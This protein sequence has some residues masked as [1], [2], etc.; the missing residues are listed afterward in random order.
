[1]IRIQA[2]L[3]GTSNAVLSSMEATGCNMDEAIADACA[4]G[5]ADVDPSVD[6]D[7]VDAA[8]K[9]AILCALAFKAR[10]RPS[11]IDARTTARVTAKML[12][13]AHERGG[14]IRQLAYAEYDYERLA[15]IAWVAPAFVSRTTIFAQMTGPKNAAVITGL[16]GGDVIV[17][18][19][20]AGGEATAMAAVGDLVAIARDRAAIVPA[21]ALAEPAEVKGLADYEFAEAV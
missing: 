15:L 9:L 4:R 18:G 7:G 16:H 11:Q 5:Y 2:I 14:T 3:N 10:V 20:G 8:A 1:V 17:S 21:P 6:L 13:L 12:G 19:T